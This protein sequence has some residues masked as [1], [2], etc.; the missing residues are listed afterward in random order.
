MR[1]VVLVSMGLVVLLA[2]CAS[3]Q[4]W[5][6]IPDEEAIYDAPL[7]EIWPSVRQFFTDS[8][9]PFRE[10]NDSF[11]LQ[12]E[13]REEFGGSKVAGFWH[14]YLVL[15]KRE[16]P[17]RGKLWVIRVT[18]SANRTLST[19]GDELSWGVDPT[20]GDNGGG[21]GS[22]GTRVS[23][24]GDVPSIGY[25]DLSDFADRPRG[26]NAILVG[27]AQGSRDL[28]MEWKVFHAVA[29][30]L[31]RKEPAEQKKPAVAKAVEVPAAPT[32]AASV[33][34]GVPIIGLVPQVNPGG[35]LLLGELHGTQEVPRFVAQGACQTAS[36]GTPVTVG[37]ELPVENQQRVAT[38][39]RSAGTE[40]DW[41][42]LMEAPFWRNPY[43]DGRAS[44]A[45]ANLLEQLR[46]L[47]SQGL[48][49]DAF[50][51]DHPEFKGQQH[52]DAMTA[53]VLSYAQQGPGRFFLVV[54]GNIHPRTIQGL[55]WDSGYRPM[56]LQLS[57][58]LEHVVALDVAYNSGSAWICAV[59]GS[60]EKLDCGVRP[61][62]GKDNGDRFFVH[63]FNQP[64]EAG[65]HGVFY[66]G[67]VT[68][69][70]P[71]VRRGL[72]RP[73][74]RDNSFQPPVEEQGATLVSR[75]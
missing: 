15:G 32:A 35:V 39:L 38:F 40:D 69:S 16:T 46:K 56:G 24:P 20:L 42:K 44:E 5:S 53:T 71:A 31:A 41:L 64:N 12:T 59:E 37:L 74:A 23:E 73:G 14:R 4:K 27:S 7:E 43:Q 45:M 30:K 19:V 52:E 57:Q 26:D 54:S 48:D 50:A 47:R 21:L 51:F 60:Q 61:A 29:P 18:R 34:C 58:K 22:N 68:A 70:L 65:Y 49:V 62:R 6:G 75:R 67:P 1:S 9:L 55:P 33:E 8:K 13:W 10:D 3:G 66:V 11:V 25:E 17:S 36:T 28:V 2:G 63:L 72:G